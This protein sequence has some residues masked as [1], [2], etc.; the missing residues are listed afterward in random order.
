[1]CRK[2]TPKAIQWYKVAA[3]W[4]NASA[5]HN[6]G[7]MY[8]QGEEV[9]PNQKEAFKWLKMAAAQ[10]SEESAAILKELSTAL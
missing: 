6:L 8:L 10:G 2:I 9:R 3:D 7:V 5:Q 4:G 1:M